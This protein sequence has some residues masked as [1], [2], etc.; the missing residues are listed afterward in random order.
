MSNAERISACIEAGNH[1]R[2]KTDDALWRSLPIVGDM[3]GLE[4]RNCTCGST[5]ARE[6]R[7]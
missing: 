5:L 6:L 4:L 2:A 7:E 1:D 3:L